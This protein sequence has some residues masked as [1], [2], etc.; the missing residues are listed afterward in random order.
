MGNSE[1]DLLLDRSSLILVNVTM[2]LT[3][4]NSIYAL[5]SN[6]SIANSTFL[7]GIDQLANGK[8]IYCN[9]HILNI[10]SSTF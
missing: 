3:K 6:L 2:N 4:S 1:T 5:Q 9:C 10:S 7:N 8:G